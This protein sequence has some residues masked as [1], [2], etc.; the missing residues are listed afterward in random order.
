M[1]LIL[2]FHEAPLRT[3][4]LLNFVVCLICKTQLV[5]LIQGME[6]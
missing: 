1:K 3:A 4:G 2:W 6:D 5:F